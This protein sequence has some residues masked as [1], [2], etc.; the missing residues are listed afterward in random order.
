MNIISRYLCIGLFTYQTNPITI[1]S[2]DTPKSVASIPFRLLL[3]TEGQMP[4]RE[5]ILLQ[6]RQATT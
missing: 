2:Y 6:L 3:N 5:K 4:Y 1:K